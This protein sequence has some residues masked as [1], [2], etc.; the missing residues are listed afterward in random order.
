MTPDLNIV[1]KGKGIPLIFQH[2]LTANV[3]Q[4]V[5][6]LGGLE[7]FQLLSLDCPGHGNSLLPKNYTPSFSRYAD[8]VIGFL[9]RQE[10]KTAIF[11]GLSMGSGIALNI[12]LRFPERVKALILLRPAW[13]DYGEPENLKILLSA[14]DF[15][16]VENGSLQFQK[17]ASYQ[18]MASRLPN[19]A[20]SVMGVFSESQQ[21]TL[22]T[23]I[24]NMVADKP[25]QKMSDLTKVNMPCLI[26]GND[27]DP[28]HPFEMAEKIHERIKGSGLVK[29]TS[30]YLDNDL[31]RMEVRENISI[32]TAQIRTQ[33]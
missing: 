33:L 1:A 31:Y 8:E 10:V 28:L 18:D 5:K 21:P 4:I 27:N 22:P 20:A 30:R 15:I 3:Q 29:L 25:L 16:E 9:D 19:A 24:K 23:V 13:L 11:G 2:G 26:L 7:R 14:A 32:F 6:L 12:A 17:L